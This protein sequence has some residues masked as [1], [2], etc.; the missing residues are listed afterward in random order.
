[1]NKLIDKLERSIG[2][3]AIKNLMRYICALYIAGFVLELF[4]PGFYSGYL[5]LNPQLI[6]RGQ[7]WRLVTFLVQPP[8]QSILIFVFVLYLYYMIG[9]TLERTW[10]AFRFNLY[11]FTGV[12]FIILGAFI[13]YFVTGYVYYIDTYYLNMSLFLAFAF[14]Y[15]DTQLLLMFLIPIKIKWLAYLDIGLFIYTIVLANSMGAR[16]S[17]LLALMNFII[18]YFLFMKKKGF[19]P[20]KFKKKMDYAR[21]VKKPAK[22]SKHRCAICGRTSDSDPELEFRF[23]SKCNGNYEYC[24]DHLFSHEH[25]TG[26]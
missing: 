16:I 1:M 15:P 4:R 9:E 12:L 6:L 20:K 10:G 7:V 17:A 21:A 14:L 26:E 18:F 24:Q 19:T 25:V 3:Y 23:C 2:R 13:S 8:N 11:Y 22:I 5:S